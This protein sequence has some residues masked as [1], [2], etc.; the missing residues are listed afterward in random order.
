MQ[1]PFNF[2]NKL[3]IM[4]PKIKMLL[5]FLFISSFC[6][7]QVNSIITTA[8]DNPT[9]TYFGGGIVLGGGQGSFQIGL[10]P[11]LLKPLN[12]HIDIGV[13]MNLYYASFHSTSLVSG[14]NYTSSN[15][16]FGLGTFIRAWPMEQFFLQVQPEYNWTFSSAK[17]T[18]QGTAGTT[19]LGAP[20]VLA[21]VG[22]GHRGENGFSYFSIMFDLVNDAKS[23][24]R[25]GQ[26]TAQPIFRAGFGFPIHWA[27]SKH[28]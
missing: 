9:P 22:Y 27:G 20:S 8:A 26:L 19:S 24:Y 18:S 3:S 16:Q 5:L 21:G 11:E 2:L 14:D 25:M 4:L 6:M 17:N 28:P 15:T 23:P 7:A 1:Y 12:E 10:N 13:S